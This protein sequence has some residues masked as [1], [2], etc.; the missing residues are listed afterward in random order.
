VCST[1]T[2][3]YAHYTIESALTYRPSS[4]LRGGRFFESECFARWL[5]RL[6]LRLRL[7]R[8]GWSFS[9]AIFLRG[10]AIAAIAIPAT[11]AML[12]MRASDLAALWLEW[13][14]VLLW[15]PSTLTP[16]LPDPPEPS[17]LDP[18]EPPLLPPDELLPPEELPPDELLPPEEL[19]PDELLLEELPP[20]PLDPPS[21]LCGCG[22]A[23]IRLFSSSSWISSSWDCFC[24]AISDD[25]DPNTA[26]VLIII[27]A[28]RRMIRDWKVFILVL[29][30][31]FF[32]F[33]LP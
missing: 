3:V 4:S 31:F 20:D 2:C 28:A 15:I 19:P 24:S 16:L 32:C 25:E 1:V 23:N 6:I 27:N 7:P 9:V 22:S 5:N 8:S 10:M 13:S 29:A 21:V 17:P 26:E 18:P 30:L 11:A 33:D 12:S 14:S